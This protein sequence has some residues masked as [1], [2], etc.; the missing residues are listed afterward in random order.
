VA[1]KDPT[2]STTEQTSACS[3]SQETQ[4][5]NEAIRESVQDRT[6]VTP[7]KDTK[8]R[9][10]GNSKNRRRSM[11]Q[12]TFGES[13][14]PVTTSFPVHKDCKPV[15][16]QI[17]TSWVKAKYPLFTKKITIHCTEDDNKRKELESIAALIGKTFPGSTITDL[18]AHNQTNADQ[19]PLI[20]LFQD[21]GLDNIVLAQDYIKLQL[22]F[23][24]N[25]SI[26]GL[27]QGCN[28][29]AFKG[30]PKAHAILYAFRAKATGATPHMYRYVVFIPI[31]NAIL[32][33]RD[34][35]DVPNRRP[36]IHCWV[37]GKDAHHTL[38]QNESTTI[39]TIIGGK[40]FPGNNK[41]K[42][43]KLI[44]AVIG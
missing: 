40:I 22:S 12:L 6:T 8:K 38:E 17:T 27:L 4:E 28:S 14:P 9:D 42:A 24:P 32:T 10:R 3:N 25:Q 11:K 13:P 41:V 18:L 20:D 7:G 39:D 35:D 30:V 26:C 33:P 16:D 5:Y 15:T 19:L 2:K 43:L 29:K 37:L 34:I 31:I 23:Q 44:S 36:D 1:A 21:Y